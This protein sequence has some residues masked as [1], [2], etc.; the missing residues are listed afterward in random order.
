MARWLN[1]SITIMVI[2]KTIPFIRR[3]KAAR[4]SAPP[5]P[6][7]PMDTH[8]VSVTWNAGGQWAEWRFDGEVQSVT[9]NPGDVL[10]I[11]GHIAG[12]W[13]HGD[14]Y[15][16]IVFYAESEPPL[17]EPGDAWHCDTTTGIETDHGG[18]AAQSGTVV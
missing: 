15:T 14:E 13:D 1:D 11:D 8:V 5:P 12:D 3:R 2:I 9:V 16:I 6:P 4:A 10:H 18:L 7:P 17:P